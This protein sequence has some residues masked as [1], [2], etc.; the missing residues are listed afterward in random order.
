MRDIKKSIWFK[1]FTGSWCP[2]IIVRRCWAFRGLLLDGVHFHWPWRPWPECWPAI[3]GC[4]VVPV[5][6]ASSTLCPD[7]NRFPCWATSS[8]LQIFLSMVYKKRSLRILYFKHLKFQKRIPLYTIDIDKSFSDVKYEPIYRIWIGYYPAVF[9]AHYKLFEVIKKSVEF[10][11]LR[12]YIR[13]WQ[14]SFV[15]V[16]TCETVHF[17]EP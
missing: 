9:V 6:S 16:F 1:T 12:T 4:G 11:V 10:S 8:I 13:Y 5:L 14:Q 15:F 2:A 3:I 7:R 17:I